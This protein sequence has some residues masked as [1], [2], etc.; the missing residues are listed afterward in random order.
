MIE[1]RQ[2]Q[3]ANARKIASENHTGLRS[4]DTKRNSRRGLRTKRKMTATIKSHFGPQYQG[5]NLLRKKARLLQSQS[6]SEQLM[7]A[8]VREVV[9]AGERKVARLLCM[10]SSKFSP[11]NS[12]RTRMVPRGR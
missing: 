7:E 4:I 3:G 12:G 2:L 1:R 9:G 10:S 5:D 8:V 11:A 6:A